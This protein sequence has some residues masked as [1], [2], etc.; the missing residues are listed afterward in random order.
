MS[1]QLDKPLAGCRIGSLRPSEVE[2]R[3]HSRCSLHRTLCLAERPNKQGSETDYCVNS[4]AFLK[5]ARLCSCRLCA[6]KR[7]AQSS[8]TEFSNLVRV[9]TEIVNLR[10]SE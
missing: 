5:L 4:Y 3:F 2:S 8:K 9:D 6:I 10:M 1:S 7:N